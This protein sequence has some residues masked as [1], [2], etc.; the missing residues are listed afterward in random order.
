M[1]NRQIGLLLVVLGVIA[2]LVG[3]LVW[4]GG[5]SWIGRLPGDIRIEGEHTRVY[6]PW[7]SMLVIS[8]V[9]TV[10]LNLLLYLLRHLF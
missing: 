10:G 2:I 3:L 8:V 6:F 4:A 5:L 1:D 9:L 7:V